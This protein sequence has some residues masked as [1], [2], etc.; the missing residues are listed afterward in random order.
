MLTA[1]LITTL[2]IFIMNLALALLTI[3]VAAADPSKVATPLI[4]VI[5]VF[6]CLI[7]ITWNIFAILSV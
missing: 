6:L 2:V 1:F 7:M 5:N 4:S 3:A